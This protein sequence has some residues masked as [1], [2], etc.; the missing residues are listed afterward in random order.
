[1]NYLT[2][3]QILLIHSLIIDETDGMHGVRD[4]H[5]ILSLENSPKQSFGGKETYPTPFQKAALYAR[6][7]ILNH[8]FIDGNK[9][10][11]MTTAIIFLENN[12]FQISI[13]QGEI[14]KF[15]LK[16][17]SEKLDIEDIA[18]WLEKYCIITWH[19]PLPLFP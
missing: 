16:I 1:M 10:T 3:E 5:I 15:A 14:E 6:N 17:V 18:A 19:T 8:P 13:P 7:I 4:R 2:K 9:R 12:D 11:G